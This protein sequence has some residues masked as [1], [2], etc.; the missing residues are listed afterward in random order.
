[1]KFAIFLAFYLLSTMATAQTVNVIGSGN[2]SCGSWLE[3]RKSATNWHQA[4]QWINGFYVAAQE[5]LLS[6]KIHL[7]QVDS[8][9]LMSFM[10]NYCR[11]NPLSTIYD[12][13]LPLVKN[14]ATPN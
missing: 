5:L 3:Q 12:G 11:E 13:T 4:G 14:L 10:D 2:N 9:A 8:Y 7:R 6:D 1:M